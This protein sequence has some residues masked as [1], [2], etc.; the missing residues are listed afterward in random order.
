VVGHSQTG[1][2]DRYEGPYTLAL[3]ILNSPTEL[4]LPLPTRGDTALNM[5]PVDYVVAAA[6]QIGCDAR[7]PGHTFHLVDPTPLPAKRAF[8]L[9]A[10]AGGRRS[11]KGHIPSYLARAVLRTPG[12]QRVVKSPRAFVEY[13]TTPVRY[14]ARSTE[15]L[16]AGTGINCPPFESYVDRLMAYLREQTRQRRSIPPPRALED[17]DPLS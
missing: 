11:P 15:E 16:L 5:V 13:L 9:L 14:D 2:I 1:E 10:Q 17:D 12:L 7:S 8:E 4:A 6:H 3:L